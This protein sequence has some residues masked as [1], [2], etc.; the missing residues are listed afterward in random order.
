MV[1]QPTHFEV[2]VPSTAK[3]GVP[4]NITIRAL[5]ASNLVDTTYTHN[6]VNLTDSS[7]SISI[8]SGSPF[9]ITNGVGTGSITLSGSDLPSWTSLTITATRSGVTGTSSGFQVTGGNPSSFTINLSS[10]N[11]TV[12]D[13]ISFTVIAKDAWNN[14]IGDYDGTVTFTSNDPQAE[15]SPSNYT[16]ISSDNGSHTF[17]NGVRFKT[18]SPPVRTITVSD[19]AIFSTSAGVTDWRINTF[20]ILNL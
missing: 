2:I 15:F 18:A 1:D 20:I 14:I 8:S 16:F 7:T 6:D 12:G 4:F 3:I 9:T 13:Y 11:V 19:G 5:D 17:T 10:L